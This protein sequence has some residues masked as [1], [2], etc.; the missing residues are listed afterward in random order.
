MIEIINFSKNKMLK[1]ESSNWIQIT[2]KTYF[3]IPQIEIELKNGFNFFQHSKKC[4]KCNSFLEKFTG[5]D[6]SNWLLK[7][8][9]TYYLINTQLKNENGEYI[10][11]IKH[12][13]SFF[14][15]GT[16]FILSLIEINETR[17]YQLEM[18]SVQLEDYES[19]CL[20]RDA[21]KEL[22]SVIVKYN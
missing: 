7:Y 20:Y 19:A 5:V 21:A 11:K 15:Y 22:K 1:F 13:I 4:G 12:T 14:E 3:E 8:N 2:P 10:S 6:Q 16:K 17:L 18:N 9:N